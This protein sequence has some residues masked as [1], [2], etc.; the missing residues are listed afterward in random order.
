MYITQN[1]QNKGWV[2]KQMKGSVKCK[3]WG[4]GLNLN[5]ILGLNY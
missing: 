4:N 1:K 5:S 3:L 2:V